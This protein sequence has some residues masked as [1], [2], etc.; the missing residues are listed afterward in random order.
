MARTDIYYY[1][2]T[3]PEYDPEWHWVTDSIALG[4]YPL[5]AALN[6]LL[7]QGVRAIM[8]IRMDEPDYDTA[9]FECSHVAL[10]EDGCP[11]PY[12][13]LVELLRFLHENVS[14]GRK[15]YVHCFAGIS[16][17][18]FVVSCYLMLTE[19]LAFEE[20]V[21]RLRRVRAIVNPNPA[22]FDRALLA[23][24]EREKDS[25]LSPAVPEER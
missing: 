12:D 20:A 9:L 18:A 22:L 5:E 17:S 16:R 10:V 6:E 23:R 8:S 1:C 14:A 21:A 7:S 13:H 3:L 24:L 2:E 25:I 11:F 15:V 4:S 19:G